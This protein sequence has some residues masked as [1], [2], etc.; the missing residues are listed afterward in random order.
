[1]KRVL[2]CFSFGLL[3]CV[4]IVG[5]NKSGTRSGGNVTD[6]DEEDSSQP[7]PQQL[8]FDIDSI[9]FGIPVVSTEG[10][11]AVDGREFTGNTGFS[12]VEMEDCTGQPCSIPDCCE[13]EHKRI[14]LQV[15]TSGVA[16]ARYEWMI[17]NWQNDG[18]HGTLAFEDRVINIDLGFPGQYVV[19][20]NSG[21]NKIRFDTPPNGQVTDCIAEIVEVIAWSVDGR[22]RNAF[23]SIYIRPEGVDVGVCRLGGGGP[24]TKTVEMFA[25]EDTYITDADI[26]GNFGSELSLNTGKIDLGT[27]QPIYRSLVKFDLSSLPRNVSIIKAELWL[28][29]AFNNTF[30]KPTALVNV[31]QIK[32][33]TWTEQTATYLSSNPARTSFLATKRITF[34]VTASHNWNVKSAV[35]DWLNNKGKN[36]GFYIKSSNIEVNGQSD[37]SFCAFYSRE[38]S[39][40]SGP[41]L[42]V[43]YE[44]P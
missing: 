9:R 44:T 18:N 25:S 30:S 29:T 22:F 35:I 43:E 7:P 14:W 39:Q 16:V 41:R 32:D 34:K 42:I 10:P 33:E 1:M 20:T 21:N 12:D 2:A 38:L 11:G 15:N 36:D 26:R 24:K 6:G 5:C 23:F 17:L 31:S 3:V 27:T 37:F 8:P 13:N 4:G 19:E 28:T 40:T